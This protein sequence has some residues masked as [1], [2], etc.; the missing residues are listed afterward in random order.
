MNQPVLAR[1]SQALSHAEEMNLILT[2]LTQVKRG[3][4]ARKA[5]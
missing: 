1:E 2:A 4:A 3:D 5:S